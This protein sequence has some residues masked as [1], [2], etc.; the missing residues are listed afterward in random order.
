LKIDDEEIAWDDDTQQSLT[1]Q[2]PNTPGYTGAAWTAPNLT[3]PSK[4]R[5][6]ELEVS[7]RGVNTKLQY[8][9]KEHM[10]FAYLRADVGD[11]YSCAEAVV[12]VRFIHTATV[13]TLPQKVKIGLYRKVGL[14][15][16]GW[17]QGIEDS[18]LSFA[19]TCESATKYMLSGDRKRDPRSDKPFSFEVG[20]S[21]TP[22]AI[23]STK[24]ISFVL[25]ILGGRTLIIIDATDSLWERYSP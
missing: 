9:T 18:K 5:P 24:K 13:D 1:L 10:G 8:C 25:Y 11:G 7:N 4:I 23:N 14:G 22:T 16:M 2:K 6:T 20:K 21:R 17:L 19:D 3:D 15:H 12:F